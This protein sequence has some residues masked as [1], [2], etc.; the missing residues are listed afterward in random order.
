[1][2]KSLTIFVDLSVFL[3]DCDAMES[4]NDRGFR[5]QNGIGKVGEFW[6]QMQDLPGVIRTMTKLVT[7][8]FVIGG[9]YERMFRLSS[10]L[11]APVIK[12]LPETC[13]NLELDTRGHDAFGNGTHLCE[14]LAEIMPRLRHLRLRLYRFCPALLGPDFLYSKWDDQDTARSKTS[15]YPF[16]E[17]VMINCIVGN[18]P[19]G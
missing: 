2:V 10:G 15:R 13:I 1:M 11:I 16:L 6:S 14:P 12:A 18:T 17:T 8:S 9:E 3:N 5:L 7:F 19:W 4:P